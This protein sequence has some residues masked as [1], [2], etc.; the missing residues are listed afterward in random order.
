MTTVMTR[1]PLP[2]GLADLLDG[3]KVES[4]RLEFKEGFHS[5]SQ[6]SWP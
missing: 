6:L 4:D 3:S 1:Y 2:V 5:D